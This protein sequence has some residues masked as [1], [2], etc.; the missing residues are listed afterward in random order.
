MESYE[1]LRQAFKKVGC[2]IVQAKMSLSLSIIH[3]WSRVK[4]GKSEARNPLDTTVQLFQITGDFSIVQWVCA[5]AGG[6][7]VPNPAASRASKASPAKLDLMKAELAL[8]HK[9]G[10]L[11]IALAEALE[12]PASPARMAVLEAKWEALKSNGEHLVR[13]L[14]R[15]EFRQQLMTWLLKFYPVYDVLTP[16]GLV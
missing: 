10:E 12:K 14:K 2:K 16:G 6:F 3:Q 11:E 15:G 5:R 1:V 4:N 8:Q 13:A 7:F 9:I